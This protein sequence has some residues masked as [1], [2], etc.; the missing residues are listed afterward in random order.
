MTQSYR[1]IGLLNHMGHGNLGNAAT[2]DAII[3]HIKQRSPDAKIYGFSLNPEDTA[4]RH[5]IPSYAIRRDS[6]VPP[7]HPSRLVNGTPAWRRGLKRRL[8]DHPLAYRLLSGLYHLLFAYPAGALREAVFLAQSFRII[9]RLRLDLLIISG[10]GELSDDWWGP[11]SFPLTLLKWVTLA[12]LAG[13]RVFFLNVG[14]SPFHSALSTILIKVSLSLAHYRSVR[15]DASRQLLSHIGFRRPVLVYPDSVYGLRFPHP[16]P[17]GPNGRGSKTVGLHAMPYC[18][19]RVWFRKDPAVYQRY[20]AETASLC[21]WLLEHG[22]TVKLFGSDIH[23]DALAISDLL[24][25][26][27]SSPRFKS[28]SLTATTVSGVPQLLSTIAAMD[29]VITPRFHGVVFSHLL[30]KPVLALSHAPKVF[31]LMNDLGFGE[32]CFPI[33]DFETNRLRAAFTALIRNEDHVKSVMR[34]TLASYRVLLNQQSDELFG[35]NGGAI[36]TRRVPA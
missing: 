10:G 25:M 11:T 4:T 16:V 7:D 35:G 3:D 2:Q 23:L 20:I 18:H 29:Y 8:K 12:R 24:K 36:T 34:R 1:N 13:V 17:L 33:E 22:H 21:L 19:P 30:N 32:Y 31:T 14:A 26:V 6:Q 9:R 5:Q 27:T 15:D 28:G